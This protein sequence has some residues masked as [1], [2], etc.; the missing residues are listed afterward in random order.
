[1][2]KLYVAI[3][4]VFLKCISTA[5]MYHF[6]GSFGSFFFVVTQVLIFHNY[7]YIKTYFLKLK[8]SNYFIRNLPSNY[9]GIRIFGMLIG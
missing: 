6:G 4:Y 5:F 2:G 3:F 8:I 1:M 7:I 9:L